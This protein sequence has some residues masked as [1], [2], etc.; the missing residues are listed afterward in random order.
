MNRLAIAFVLGLG[1]TLFPSPLRAEFWYEP[2][3]TPADCAIQRCMQDREIREHRSEFL[4][5]DPHFLPKYRLYFRR[6][7]ECGF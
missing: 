2:A 4:V 6:L 7:T 5:T 1:T 3:W